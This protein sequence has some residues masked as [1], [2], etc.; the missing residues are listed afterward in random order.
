MVKR[1]LSVR[2]PW[3]AESRLIGILPYRLRGIPGSLKVKLLERRRH[4]VGC[5]WNAANVGHVRQAQCCS[6]LLYSCCEMSRSG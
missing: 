3:P 6:L 2:E 1:D 5:E 4:S